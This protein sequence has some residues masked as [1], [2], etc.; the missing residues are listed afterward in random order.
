MR[1]PPAYVPS[2]IAVAAERITQV[3]TAKLSVRPS[4]TSASTITPIVFW[5]S[6]APCASA[7]SEPEPICASRKPRFSGPG[8]LVAEAP[9]H[10]EHDDRRDDESDQ[11]RDR[12]PGSATRLPITSQ[13]IALDPAV[14]QVA[15][16]RPPTSAYVDDDGSAGPPGDEVPRDRADQR[17]EH[18][19]VGD[20]V[21][22]HDVLADRARDARRHERADEVH[23]RCQRD[24]R[25]RR[26][27]ARRDRGGDGVRRVVEAVRE[28]EDECG[29]HDQHDQ[30][31][32]VTSP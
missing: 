14:T 9:V 1:Q 20:R 23:H 11:R 22:V 29:R 21:D 3:G 19:L 5:A 26:Q 31:R 24:G 2:A 10:R 18:E 25:A 32:A 17:G 6:L 30:H 16:I 13:R 27:R 8:T 4:A 12:A 7:T 15:P 28:V